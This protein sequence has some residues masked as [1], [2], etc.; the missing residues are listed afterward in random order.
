MFI[1]RLNISK[2]IN[3]LYKNDKHIKLHLQYTIYK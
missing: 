2:N 1:T 3:K